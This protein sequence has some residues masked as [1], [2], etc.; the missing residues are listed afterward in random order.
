[1]FNENVRDFCKIIIEPL[2][3]KIANLQEIYRKCPNEVNK[4]RLEHSQKLLIKYYKKFEDVVYE[5][6]LFQ[7]ELNQK[8]KSSH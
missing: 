6:Y 3:R 4:R 7:K 1:M 2:E 8:I 5:E